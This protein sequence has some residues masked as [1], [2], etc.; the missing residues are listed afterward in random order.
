MIGAAARSAEEARHAVLALA[1]A[2]LHALCDGALF[3]PDENLLVVSDL[4]LE[5]GSSFARRGQLLP[6]FDSAVTLARLAA[7]IAHHAPRRVIALGDSFHDTEGAAR[8]SPDDRAALA[9]L[10]AGRDWLWILGNHDPEPDETVGGD[11]SVSLA[12]SGITFVHEPT[13][14]A[15]AEIAGHLHPCARVSHRGRGLSRR[16]FATDAARIIVPAFGAYTGGLSIRHAAF[17]PLFNGTRFMAHL[18][19]AARVFS[20]PAFACR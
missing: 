5:K 19:G 4:H 20:L 15:R 13:A 18:V 3:W 10:M 11:F 7:L 8:L 16:C 9:A 12:W 6:P 17:A 1:G 2:E 14:G